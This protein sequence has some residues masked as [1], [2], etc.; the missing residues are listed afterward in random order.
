[1]TSASSAVSSATRLPEGFDV[2][3]LL[4]HLQVSVADERGCILHANDRFCEACGY[5]R[6][7]LIGQSYRM[8]S[9]GRQAP[10]FF[11]ELWKTVRAGL[12]WR[13]ELSNRRKD[14]SEFWVELT[15]VPL[16]PDADGRRRFVGIGSDIT[17][18]VEAELQ[19]RRSEKRFRGLAETISAAIL[20]HRGDKLL[21]ANRAAERITGYG[22]GQLLEMSIPDLAHPDARD[23]VRAR[24]AARLRGEEV[25]EVYEMPIVT[26]NSELRWLEVNATLMEYED[27]V[28][29]L[30]TAIDV[31]ERKRAEAAQRHMQQVLQQIIEGDPVPTFVI[32][33]NHVVTHWNQACSLVTG[34]S[35]QALVGSRRAWS[36][37]Y[38]SERPVLAELIVDGDIEARIETYYRGRFRRSMVIP[39]AYEAESFF[40]HFGEHGRWLF[41]T[42]A[43]L[44]DTKGRIIGAIETLVDISARKQAEEALQRAHDELEGLVARRTEQLARANQALEQDMR[45]RE[46]SEREL[47]RRNMEL[48]ELNRRLQ[49]AQAQLLQSEKLA[50]IGQLAAGVAHEINNP[51][52]YVQSNLGTLSR[53]LDDMREVIAA[54]DTAAAQLP[55]EHPAAQA[56]ARV[57]QARDFDFIIDDLPDLLRQSCEGVD[58]V[59]RIVADLKDF[60]RLD[61]S[62]EW[63]SADLHHGLDSTLNIVNNEIKYRA[64][65]VRDYGTLPEVECLPSQLNQVFLNLLVNAAH[66][67]PPERMGRILLRSGHEPGPEGGQV[68][69]SVGDD[70]CGIPPENL[71]RIF[72]PFFTTK[73]VGKGT[74]LGL[75]LSY[76]IVQRHNGRI[77]VDSTPGRGTTFRVVL[78]VRQATPAGAQ[79]ENSKS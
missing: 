74:G 77:E 27:G 7:E 26:A 73:P 55:S 30:A 8:L 11:H 1:M 5:G 20:L 52:G 34:T 35:A 45:R 64:E 42:A 12:N 61:G 49:E 57:R 79:S 78:P 71:G 40:P 48:T 75:S 9:S 67:M 39:G 16:P 44:R 50:S 24:I 70:G 69:I 37:F 58:R 59:G 47:L 14:G 22:H 72:D 53:Y 13:G 62:Q 31:T 46:A 28:A 6:E 56:L 51:I 68:W 23:A 66:A 4:A 65:V 63:Q 19:F 15:V 18:V 76:G 38:P 29:V 41:F 21:Y 54:F 43:P 33:A 3:S 2:A 10:D 60:S 32:D 17:R 36:A 25:P